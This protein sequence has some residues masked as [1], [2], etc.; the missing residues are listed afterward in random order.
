MGM[1]SLRSWVISLF[2]LDCAGANSDCQEH[3]L[4]FVIN[5]GDSMHA[6]VEDDIRA[7]LEKLGMTVNA[8][9]MNRDDLN[10]AMTSGNF[11]LCFSE[12]WGAPYDP[13][14]FMKGWKNNNEAHYSAMSGVTGTNS[15]QNVFDAL[16]E[17]AVEQNAVEKQNKWDIIHTWVHQ[18][19]VNLPLWGKRIP[20]VLNERL[21][22]YVPGYQQ[23]DYPV[24]TIV[25][26]GSTTVT[27]A[28]GARTGLFNTVGP[29]DPHSYGPNEFFSNN[30][31]Y[32]G[33]VSYG[34]DGSILPALATSWTSTGTTTTFQLRQGVTFTDGQPW[35]CAAAKLNFDHA[36]ASPL[37]TGDYHLWYN[38]PE[39]YTG[40]SCATNGDF[41]ITTSAP[42]SVTLLELSF[43][44]PL[45]MLSPGSFMST[46]SDSWQTHNSCPT[47][48]GADA[49]NG[50][51]TITHEGVTITC[52]GISDPVGTGPF[53]F[54]SKTEAT[55]DGN[56]VNPEVTF[57][58]NTDYWGPVPAI[59][60]LVIKRYGTASEVNAALLDDSLDM[61]IGD[62]V[63]L[64]SDLKSRMMDSN[65]KTSWTGVI[66]HTIIIINSGKEPTND[67]SVRKTIIHGVDKA[68][69]ITK[70]LGGIGTAV[71]RVFPPSAPYSSVELT[72]RWDYDWEKATMLNCPSS[73]ST[74][75]SDDE[76]A[77]ALGLGL[78]LGLPLLA[79]IIAS[80]VFFMGKKK[81]E[82][83][84]KKALTGNS[85]PPPDADPPPTVVGSV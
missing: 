40:C 43:I 45:R 38:L 76:L 30:W 49:D 20:A 51:F 85:D 17:V 25:P 19:A 68:F 74:D 7:E 3:T 65:F 73:G 16:D 15:R 61:V 24:H 26:T 84:L 78:G 41:T 82:G 6:A 21:S 47:K 32:E 10:D 79:A 55:V 13:L 4:D 33:L 48:W 59:E 46:A 50:D 64:P 72:P 53:K 28:P 37:R 83:E 39:I 1:I 9:F 54:V 8:N 80:V 27:I 81:A 57:Q 70:E 77:L 29:M 5:E 75:D 71:D 31:V 62:G 60:T 14:S 63:L 58:R 44:R 22:G 52:A 36:F 34:A 69:I 67:I 66:Q 35:N 2:L 18:Q 42:S 12:T 23:F 11:H 56:T